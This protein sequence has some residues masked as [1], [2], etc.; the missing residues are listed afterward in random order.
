MSKANAPLPLGTV[1]AGHEITR[2]LGQGG[3]G[4]TYE[5]YN[6][7]VDSRLAIK[8][9]FPRAMGAWREGATH[10]AFPPDNA[11][12]FNWALGRFRESTT[13][14]ARLR[15]NHILRVMNYVSD[16]GTGYMLMEHVAGETLSDWLNARSGAPN[17]VELK[18]LLDPV[19]DAIQYVHGE[20]LLHRDIA[21]DNIMIRESGEPVLIDFGETKVIEGETRTRLA[22]DTKVKHGEDPAEAERVIISKPFYSSPEQAMGAALDA[23]ADLYSIAAVLYR[24]LSG[25]PPPDAGARHEKTSAGRPDPYYSLQDAA[26]QK[27]PAAACSAIDRA[28]SIKRDQ[29]PDRVEELRE[30]L[31]PSEPTKIV[32]TEKNAGRKP[33]EEPEERSDGRSRRPLYAAL[34][35]LIIVGAATASQFIP[36]RNTPSPAP[37]PVVIVPKPLDAANLEFFDRATGQPKV[38]FWKSS[39]GDYE[40]FDAEGFHPR[41]GAKLQ[42]MDRTAIADWERHERD[43]NK[44]PEPQVTVADGHPVCRSRFGTQA[45]ATAVNADKSFQCA[46][47]GDYVWN[48]ERSYCIQKVVVA[49]PRVVPL[50]E[51]VSPYRWAIGSTANCNSATNVYR[52]SFSGGNVVWRDASGKVY[53]EELLRNDAGEFRTRTI[54]SPSDSAGTQWTYAQLSDDRIQVIKNNVASAT[55]VR[56]P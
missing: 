20:K 43:K 53:I 47:G 5:G 13:T 23:R 17:L 19:L 4:I 3:F 49:P 44:K 9:F 7:V 35:I 40:F 11:K 30:I 32:K 2:V 51:R 41:S 18:P 16:H 52:L 46:C 21:P 14:L 6:R 25:N 34:A 27:L 28:L 54:Q 26:T 39:S 31:W 56:C 10:V 33:T 42:L 37:T 36:S 8:E 24:A 38:W 29:R 15:H 22:E 12:I 48:S 1:I 50:T 45:Y 55:I